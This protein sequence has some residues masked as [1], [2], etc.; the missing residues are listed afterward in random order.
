MFRSWTHFLKVMGLIITFDIACVLIGVGI[1]H[2][3][4]NFF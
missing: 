2:L 4:K 1:Y 3:V